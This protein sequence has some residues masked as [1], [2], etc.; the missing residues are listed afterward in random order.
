VSE[1]SFVIPTAPQFCFERVVLSHGWL[2]LPPFSW[3]AE[4][5]ALDYVYQ[6]AAG[7]VL[8]LRMRAAAGGVNL[9]LPDCEVATDALRSEVST[10]AQ[11]MLRMDWD[12]SAFYAA[13]AAHDGYQW[14]ERE[15]RGRILSAPSLWEDLA[16]VLL[17][18]NCNWSQTVN[19]CQQLCRLGA[20]H[21]TLDDSY[22]FPRAE[23][24]AA[25]SFDA[26]AEKA[27]AGY[28]SAYLHQLARKI[29]DGAI[30]LDAWLNLDSD[31]FFRAVKS[32]KGFGDYAAGTLARMYGHFD[33]IAID[34]ACHA[35]FA[36]RHNGGAKGS[37]A[38]IKAHYA[39]F[40]RWRGLLM[41]MDIMRHYDA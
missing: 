22:A 21:P 23:R 14:L 40:G 29:A 6:S 25:L 20:R 41:W 8:R 17:T 35:M 37:V 10:A 5:G 7:D 33:H 31:S 36:A 12:L 19:M 3:E 24:I 34:S 2:M 39:S 15:R 13:M 32:L 1:T 18:T 28:R 9:E 11:T 4:S 30:N 16:K 38:A 26:F 27:R